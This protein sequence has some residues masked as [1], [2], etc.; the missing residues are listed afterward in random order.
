MAELQPI[1]LFHGRH[2]VH[3]LRICNPICVKLLP[4]MSG[5]IPHN[6]KKNDV[7]ISNRFPGVHKRIIHTDTQTHDDSIRRNARCCISPTNL[8]RISVAGVLHIELGLKMRVYVLRWLAVI[9]DCTGALVE[10]DTRPARHK[11]HMHG[12]RIYP[13]HHTTHL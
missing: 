3:H 7:S 5:V 12:H 13:S 9:S 2:F 11:Q 10:N 4:I 1:I 6:F 8:Y